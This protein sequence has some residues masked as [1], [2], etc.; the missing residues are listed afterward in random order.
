[1]LAQRV[2]SAALGVPIII[3][4]IYAGGPWYVAAVATA[5][6]IA[7]LEFQHMRRDWL[8]PVSLLTAA[9]AGG[10]AVGAYVGQVEWLAWIAGALVLTP[11]AAAARPADADRAIDL[12]WTL[13]G[14]TYVGFLGSF[15]VLLRYID[16]DGRD[17]VLLALISTFA[18][19]TA[20]YFTG[21]IFGR[22]ALAPRISPKKTVEGFA[23]G[24]MAGFA[25]VLLCNYFF[26]LGTTPAQ[27]TGLAL[28][29]PPAATL[30]DLAESAIKRAM[31]VKDASELIP[32]HGGVLDRLDSVLF[33]FAVTYLFTQWVVY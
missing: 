20:A 15:I 22:H 26:D 21:R 23:G 5:L 16:F 28:A 31:D 4:L 25:A 11:L 1:M 8:D 3:L 2:G 9:L 33:T 30:G 32:G 13:G 29:L 19:D 17:W 18:I 24:Y 10:I 14:V 6:A 12:L 27:I 7:T